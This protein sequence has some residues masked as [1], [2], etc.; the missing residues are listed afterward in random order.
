MIT[1]TIPLGLPAMFTISTG[2]EGIYLSKKGVLI[3]NLNILEEAGG[4]SV[5]FFGNIRDSF[6]D[7]TG[8]LTENRL[9]VADV[10]PSNTTDLCVSKMQVLEAAAMATELVD[11]DPIDRAILDSANEKLK[12]YVQLIKFEAFLLT[13]HRYAKSS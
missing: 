11:P 3:T 8:T 1:G 12:R 2:L 5:L 6:S 13:F 7:K 10:Y 4:L 9:K